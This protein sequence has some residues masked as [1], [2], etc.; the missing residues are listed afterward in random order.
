MAGVLPATSTRGGL[1]GQFEQ[2]RPRV[3]GF[4]DNNSMAL[5]QFGMGLLSGGNRGEA[6][7]N[8]SQGL[9]YGSQ[10][11]QARRQRTKEEEEK[12]AQ[13]QAVNDL[14]M[15]PEFVE[16]M[17]GLSPQEQAFFRANPEMAREF[18]MSEIQRRTTPAAGPDPTDDMREYEFARSQ[19][20]D[21]SF[22]EWQMLRPPSTVINNGPTGIDYG[23][24][25]TS[26][27]WA[28]NPDGT[29][30]IDER[31]APV[32]LPVGPALADQQATEAAGAARES[33]TAQT[34][35]IV[36]DK[37]GEA[38]GQVN[39]WTA[40]IGQQLLGGVGGT[41]QF[42]LAA[43]LE[44]IGANI[45][46]DAL[47]AMRDSSP[48]GG[49]LGQ[50][51]ERELALLKATAGNIDPRQSP[52]QLRANLQELQTLYLNTIHGEG[53]WTVDA[54]GRVIVGSGS[55][56]LRQP[57]APAAAPAPPTPGTV[58]DGYRF[59]GGDPADP[60]NWTRVN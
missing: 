36:L 29:V 20:F 12:A 46:F 53:N 59:N 27:A 8:A 22:Q 60:N 31:G 16:A 30:Q 7:A 52:T 14:L 10:A 21:G 37:I 48:T 23:Q 57:G 17:G 5:M 32:A 2:R 19:G 56:N 40:G 18:A 6:W 33:Q 4:L 51:T 1:L 28:R 43:T 49:A 9:A 45:A 15:S 34:N 54:D 41:G 24:P 47:Q 11:D 26:H 55:V 38:L 25:P 58:M 39:G 3:A 42:D 50:V 13:E 35:D 44:T